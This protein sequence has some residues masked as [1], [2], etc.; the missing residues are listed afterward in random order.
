MLLVVVT[1]VNIRTEFGFT[2]LHYSAKYLPR[3]F[4][5]NEAADVETASVEVTKKSSSSQA[6][7]LLLQYGANINAQDN[8]GL[9]PLAIACQRGNYFVVERLLQVEKIEIAL[10]D[11]QKSTA[12]HEACKSGTEKIVELLLKSGANILA[13][14]SDDVTPLHIAC[15]EGYSDIVNLLLY[16]GHHKRGVL[17]GAKD[18]QGN[19]PLHFA[20]ESGV[21]SIVKIL[22]LAG[23]DPIAQK[24]NEVTPLHIAARNGHIAIAALLLQCKSESITQL[25]VI[26]M[27]DIEQNTPLH[28]AARYNQCKMIQYLVER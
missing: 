15:R 4:N 27:I 6:V 24:N 9:T 19:R 10:R 26:E 3:I 13:T 16:Y 18:V 25:D 7:S 14:D 17:V 23:A 11:N 28:F 21:E 8:D 1:D 20:V 12:L 2:P 5:E 22:L